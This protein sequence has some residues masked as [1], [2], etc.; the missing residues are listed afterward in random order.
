[1]IFP[2]V[3]KP[4]GCLDE[5]PCKLV[6]CVGSAFPFSDPIVVKIWVKMVHFKESY[7]HFPLLGQ[8]P[9]KTLKPIAVLETSLSWCLYFSR[10]ARMEASA[11][12][13]L[14]PDPNHM[15][16]SHENRTFLGNFIRI[17]RRERV[18]AGIH[19]NYNTSTHYSTPKKVV[20][21]KRKNY[22]YQNHH[23][24]VIIVTS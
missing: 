24:Y 13:G 9:H 3:C 2:S 21:Q 17:L 16:N 6:F 8:F 23:F 15:E 1:M 14:H 4:I 10:I 12:S 7:G 18:K 19:G 5:T 20:F 11:H 22:P